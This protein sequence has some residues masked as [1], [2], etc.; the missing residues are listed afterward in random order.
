MLALREHLDD[1]DIVFGR[2]FAGADDAVNAVA[3]GDRE[4]VVAELRRAEDEVF[5]RRRAG[6]KAEIRPRRQFDV[7]ALPRRSYSE[8]MAENDKRTVLS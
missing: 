2:L 5:G 7:T 6:Q 8:D 1:A 3:V 4:R